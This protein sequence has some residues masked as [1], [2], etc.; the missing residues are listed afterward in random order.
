MTNIAADYIHRGLGG[1]NRR[2]ALT[3]IIVLLVAFGMAVFAVWL[4][5]ASGPNPRRS[6]LPYIVGIGTTD[7]NRESI[8]VNYS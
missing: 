5:T 4:G 7:H 1:L 8:C 2:P 3:V 6:E